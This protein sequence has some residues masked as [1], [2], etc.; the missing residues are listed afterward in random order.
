M[1]TKRRSVTPDPRPAAAG[2]QPRDP[3]DDVRQRLLSAAVAVLRED[4][5]HALTQTRVAER[6]RLRQSHLTYYFPRR[7][8]LLM[9]VAETVASQMQARVSVQ[10]NGRPLDIDG[11]R[12]VLH[13]QLADRELPRLMLALVAAAD[14]DARLGAW[15]VRF[16]AGIAAMLAAALARAG[17]EA[18]ADALAVFQATLVGLRVGGLM[19]GARPAEL[20]SRLDRA[21]DHLL[22]DSSRDPGKVA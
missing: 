16:H 4:G 17:V 19:T 20:S 2:R 21:L 3:A 10:S 18:P 8:D 22:A 1:T 12:A 15:L 5:F 9:A 6:S 7:A 13:A 11:L 14:E